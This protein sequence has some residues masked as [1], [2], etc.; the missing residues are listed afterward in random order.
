MYVL[1]IQLKGFNS[2]QMIFD[3]KV[4]GMTKIW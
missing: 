2:N 4:K 1:D 3:Y